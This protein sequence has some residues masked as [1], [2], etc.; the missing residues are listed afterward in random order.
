MVNVNDQVHDTI[1]NVTAQLF[2]KVENILVFVEIRLPE[3]ENDNNYERILFKTNLNLARMTFE[4]L[5]QIQLISHITNSIWKHM[6]FKLK[7]PLDPVSC[8]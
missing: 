7:F 6:D 3:N 5:A 2:K 8:S 4:K 1:L